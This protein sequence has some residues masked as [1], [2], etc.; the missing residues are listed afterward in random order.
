[1]PFQICAEAEGGG[2]GGAGV[3]RVVFAVEVVSG[4]VSLV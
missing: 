2:A 4:G 3:A 1:M